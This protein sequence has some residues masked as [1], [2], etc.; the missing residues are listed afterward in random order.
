[1]IFCPRADGCTHDEIQAGLTDKYISKAYST[2]KRRNTCKRRPSFS[3]WETLTLPKRVSPLHKIKCYN[4]PTITHAL[5]QVPK[6]WP[7]VLLTPLV[8]S[9][10]RRTVVKPSVQGRSD[11]QVILHRTYPVFQAVQDSYKWRISDSGTAAYTEERHRY[12]SC[13]FSTAHHW[14]AHPNRSFYHY[15]WNR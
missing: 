2:E 12:P 7:D 4:L 6:V 15:I 11:I 14:N 10:E 9:V 1:V 8:Q 5:L 13:C 3:F